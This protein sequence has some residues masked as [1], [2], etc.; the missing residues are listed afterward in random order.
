[1][2][3]MQYPQDAHKV[4]DSLLSG[5]RYDSSLSVLGI[6]LATLPEQSDAPDFSAF[7]RQGGAE[8]DNAVVRD[9]PHLLARLAFINMV[10]RFES[11]MASFLY[12]R[13]VVEHV[14]SSGKQMDTESW[15]DI[16]DEVQKIS[17]Q[18]LEKLCLRIAQEPDSSLT[19]RLLWLTGLIGVRNC[20]IHR[21]GAVQMVDVKKGKGSLRQVKD[22]DLLSAT[23]LR[24]NVVHEDGTPVHKDPV[25]RGTPINVRFDAVTRDWKI[26]DTI[27]LDSD[28]CQDLARCLSMIATG[29]LNQFEVEMNKLLRPS[30]G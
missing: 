27:H 3:N 28:E 10:C 15:W 23:W 6:R 29:V 16:L 25:S 18:G 24:F 19:E 12:Q 5:L 14:G 1:M 7:Y 13:L 20:L 26:G 9:A 30:E 2:R 4:I 17:R 8:E 21:F 22:D 11:N